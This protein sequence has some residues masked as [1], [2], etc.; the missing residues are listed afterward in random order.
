MRNIM[1]GLQAGFV[2]YWYGLTT[3][4]GLAVDSLRAHKLRSF[5]TLLG[6]IIGVGSVVLV[7]AAIEGMGLYA[8]QST[9]KIFGSESFLLAQVGTAGNYRE[10]I[11]KLKRNKRIRAEDLLYLEATT[12]DRV[13][14]SPYRVHAE[15]FKH[16]GVTFEE[17]SLLGVGSALPEIRDVTLVEGRFFTEQEQRT[18][19]YVAVIAEDVRAM[20][21]PNTTAVGK[22]LKIRGLDFEVIGVQEKLGSAFGRSQ[23]NSVYIPYTVFTRLYGTGQ[24][25]SVFGRPRSGL[26]LEEALDI[27]RVSLRTR[28]RVRPGQPDRFD[29]VTPDAIRSFIDNL[30]KMISAVVVPVTGISLVVGG[31][32]IMNIMLV[33]VTERT[34][35]IGVRK[36]LGARRG[37]ILLQFLLEAVLLSAAGGAMGLGLGAALTE[38]LSRLFEISM[39]IT[40]PYVFLSLF[41]SSVVGILSGWYPAAR[42]SKLDPVEALRAE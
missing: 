8:E 2:R 28:F 3:A 13:L 6:V 5:L 18:R 21:Y 1:G 11:E 37:D 38:L 10:Y 31:I 22:A 19:Q 23:D 7:G 41:V 29:T 25:I 34:H 42:A 15:E 4:L 27:S 30:L 39:R 12:G 16:N 36:S 24:S 35:E 9:S 14:Y 40:P 26:T 33:S 20:L 17:G 32:V